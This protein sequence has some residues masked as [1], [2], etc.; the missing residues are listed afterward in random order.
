MIK[1]MIVLVL[2]Q[3]SLFKIYN[4]KENSVDFYNHPGNNINAAQHPKYL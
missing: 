1:T 4:E 3:L 2:P